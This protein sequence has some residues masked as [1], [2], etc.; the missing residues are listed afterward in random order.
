VT[1]LAAIPSAR[2]VLAL[3]PFEVDRRTFELPGDEHT[4]GQ[5]V[6]ALGGP[7]EALHVTIDGVPV[8]PER[9]AETTIPGGATVLVSRRPGAVVFPF[10]LSL[11]AGTGATVATASTLAI[12]GAAVLTAGVAYGVSV[13]ANKLFAPD[14]P[15]PDEQDKGVRRTIAGSRN[16]LTPYGTV[17]QVLGEHRLYPPLAA[18]SYTTVED[19]KLVQYALFTAGHGPLTVADLKIGEDALFA[20]GT[21]IVYTGQMKANAD[22][23]GGKIG[24]SGA[25]E[26]GNQVTLEIRQG[27]GSDAAITLFSTDVQELVIARPLTERKGWVENV[28]PDRT[29]NIT[30]I[31]GWPNGLIWISDTGKVKETVVEVDIEY[32]RHGSTDAWTNLGE[33]VFQ[34]DRNPLTGKKLTTGK[35]VTAPAIKARD[36]TNSSVYKSKTWAVTEGQYDVRVKR[37]TPDATDRG[38]LD[39]TQWTSLLSTRAGT[40]VKQTGL[41]QIAAR[42]VLTGNFN[43]VV[44]QLNGVFQTVCPDWNTGTQTWITRATSNPASLYRHV[45]QGAANRRP[46]TDAQINLTRLAAW[47]EFC[48]TKSFE[49]RYVTQGRSSVKEI[50][51]AIA[52]AGRATSGLTDGKFGVVLDPDTTT[53]TPTFHIG[54][55]NSRGFR[56]TRSY[57]QLP[58]AFKVQFVDPESGYLDTERIVPDDGYT[59][60]TAATFDRLDMKGIANAD[61]AYKLGRYHIA[62]LRLRPEEFIVEMDMEHLDMLRGDWGYLSHDVPLLGLARGRVVSVTMSGGDC[63][64][65]VVDETCSMTS[66]TYGIRFRKSTGATI[67][68][69]LTLAVGDQTTLTF[70]TAITAGN[71]MPVAGDWFAFG[72]A[73][74][75]TSKVVVKEIRPLPSGND[76]SYLSAEVVLFDAAP[77]VLTADSTTIPKYDPQ[78][79]LPPGPQKASK[80]L[81]KPAVASVSSATQQSSS[82]SGAVSTGTLRIQLAPAK[83]TA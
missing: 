65:V 82:A 81:A 73:G 17:P 46:A 34:Y 42:V 33:R 19:G 18:A 75:E 59:V 41:C 63:T 80:A 30:V 68:K 69:N 27:G 74:S 50:L 4:V 31:V 6:E 58:N 43:S 1:A 62:Q 60:A 47:H 29:T 16:S 25:R 66:G 13:L 23:W 36:D 24:E 37:R 22:K 53:V 61:Q 14:V 76:G 7:P 78:I 12:I 11:L 26:G 10:F 38:V 2:V 79:T 67:Q 54:P 40:P 35:W 55:H 52:A 9:F 45:L 72:V 56:A 51:S 39:D 77:G 3:S 48:D 20:E 21:T 32:R 44:D 57:T 71:P 28:T 49:F 15:D 8:E 5:V 70:A 83:A 64:G